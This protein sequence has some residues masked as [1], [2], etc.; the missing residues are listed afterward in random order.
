M[1]KLNAGD[2]YCETIEQVAEMCAILAHKEGIVFEAK[3][4]GY[5]RHR[6]WIITIEYV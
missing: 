6:T 3:L 5:D 4:T 1:Y 2:I